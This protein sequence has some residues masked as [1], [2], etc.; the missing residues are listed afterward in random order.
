MSLGVVLMVWALLGIAGWAVADGEGLVPDV[1]VPPETAVAPPDTNRTDYQVSN[2]Q[3][4]FTFLPLIIGAP[5]S[6]V[7]GCS[8]NTAEQEVATRAISHPDQGR[9]TMICDSTLAQEAREKAM[10]MATRGYFG[11][12]D[13]DGFGPNYHVRNA[14]YN[15]PNWYSSDP[16]ANN[17][18]S[19]AAGY[20]TPAAAWQGWLNSAGHRAHVLGESSFWADQTHYGV[21]YYYDPDSYYKHYWVFMSAPPE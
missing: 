5:S 15:L 16:N 13:P 11:H 2:S 9:G 1:N 12:V 19:I 14:G 4:H 20:A 21:G 10:D 8:L 3:D 7:S 18:E 6:S 17:I